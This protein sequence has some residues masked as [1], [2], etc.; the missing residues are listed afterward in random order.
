MT[1]VAEFRAPKQRITRPFGYVIMEHPDGTYSVN[2][3][4]YDAAGSYD[5][6]TYQ[7]TYH[8]AATIF[9]EKVKYHVLC[10]PP[11]V[12]DKGETK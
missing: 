10:Y 2:R 9:A 4:Y 7:L 11:E 6:G 3:K 1:Y 5:G 12:F 8:E